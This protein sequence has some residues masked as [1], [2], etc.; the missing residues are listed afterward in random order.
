MTCIVG[1]IAKGTV[2]IGADSLSGNVNDYSIGLVR[3]PKIVRQSIKSKK[4]GNADVLIGYTSSWRMGNLFAQMEFPHPKGKDA[5]RYLVE[6]FVPILRQEFSKSGF[7][8]VRDSVERGGTFL[9]AINNR[10]FQI[11]NDFAVLEPLSVYDACGSG[12]AYAL[13][14]FNAICSSHFSSELTPRQ[15]CLAALEAASHHSAYVSSPYEFQSLNPS[16]NDDGIA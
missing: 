3:N 14:A 2:W 8:E 11:Q 7:L 13:G 16:L 10:L 1:L 6:D 15:I 9:I 5:F 12:G 4:H